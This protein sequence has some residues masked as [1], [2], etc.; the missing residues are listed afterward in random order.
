MV[1]KMEK[2]IIY[3]GVYNREEDRMK[4]LVTLLTIF[5][6]ALLVGCGGTGTS[7]SDKKKVK[8]EPKASNDSVKVEVKSGE[9]SVIPEVTKDDS[10]TL[11]L[12]INVSNTGKEKIVVDSYAFELYEEDN[13]EK[14]KAEDVYNRDINTFET[15]RLSAGKNVTGTIFFNVDPKKDYKLVYSQESYG[16]SAEDEDIELDLDLSKYAD[17]TKVFDESQ[18]AATA[19]IDVQFLGKENED[20]DKLVG[21]NKD[22]TKKEILEEYQKE[23]EDMLFSELDLK[24]EDYKKSFD[25]FTLVQGKRAKFDKDLYAQFDDQAVVSI[26][27]EEALSDYAIEE[28]FYEYEEKY[29]DSSEDYDGADKYAYSKYKEILEK[30]KLKGES[31]DLLLYLEKKDGKWNV[32]LSLDDNKYV[33][34]A[35]IGDI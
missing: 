3:K 14:I 4:K 11:A 28:L 23:N 18:K 34:S 21:N 30:S 33:I 7:D 22:E 31:E 35:F 17:S 32:D 19:F 1:F 10:S 2:L 26:D 8:V 5:C 9:Y 25:S 16:D 29:M 6:L 12:T 20:Y 13:G 24:D 27:M 15:E